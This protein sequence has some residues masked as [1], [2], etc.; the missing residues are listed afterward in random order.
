[1]AANFISSNSGLSESFAS[2]LWLEESNGAHGGELSCTVRWLL[3]TYGN[4][5]IS[6]M[7]PLRFERAG[8]PQQSSWALGV[9]TFST[10][11]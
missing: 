5:E 8:E 6:H 3:S 11:T 7:T 2:R 1:M 9:L 10:A 4:A